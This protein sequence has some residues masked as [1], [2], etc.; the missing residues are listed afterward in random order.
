MADS[1]FG[2]WPSQLVVIEKQTS[3]RGIALCVTLH[4]IFISCLSLIEKAIVAGFTRAD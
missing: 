3:S 4:Y 2:T 1:S